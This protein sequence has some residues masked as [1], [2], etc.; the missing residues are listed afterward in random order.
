[1]LGQLSSQSR[2]KFGVSGK[3]QGSREESLGARQQGRTCPLRAINAFSTVSMTWVSSTWL[4]TSPPS[5][6]EAR[7]SP[8]V[9]ART[10]IW[11]SRSS[12]WRRRLRRAAS[13]RAG[14]GRSRP[15]VGR[16][17]WST[18]RSSLYEKRAPRRAHRLAGYTP[19]DTFSIAD[20]LGLSIMNEYIRL[21]ERR[22]SSMAEQRFCKAKTGVRFTLPAP[23]R[24]V[25]YVSNMCLVDQT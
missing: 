7:V 22:Y 10:Q 18:M 12:T 24:L 6:G 4:L 9:T 21:E 23:I 8:S 15:A 13:T 16:S 2:N 1:M 14:S 19:P 25:E 17:A 3:V 5:I 20:M 11:A